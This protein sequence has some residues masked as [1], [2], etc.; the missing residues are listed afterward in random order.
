MLTQA[1][2]GFSIVPCYQA[3][4]VFIIVAGELLHQMKYHVTRPTAQMTP[5]VL[6]AISKISRANDDISDAV[7][8][9]HRQNIGLIENRDDH[10]WWAKSGN[11]QDA[12]ASVYMAKAII[13]FTERHEKFLVNAPKITPPQLRDRRRIYEPMA[14]HQWKLR[15]TGSQM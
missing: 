11:Y 14:M 10:A 5:G 13:I 3:G 1:R 4:V 2:K 7:S 9:H 15:H 12:R 6:Y 8:A